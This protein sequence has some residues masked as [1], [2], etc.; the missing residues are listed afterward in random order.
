M[1]RLL[2]FILLI[3]LGCDHPGYGKKPQSVAEV[4]RHD[5][6]SR[7]PAAKSVDTIY[8]LLKPITAQ[9]ISV[10]QYAAY[11]RAA[12]EAHEAGNPDSTLLKDMGNRIFDEGMAIDSTTTLYYKSVNVIIYTNRNGEKCM[13]E[14]W[15]F[16]DKELK[17][18]PE[19]SFVEK[20]SRNDD[21]L[22]RPE[23]YEP[24]TPDDK[25]N[26]LRSGFVEYHW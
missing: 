2:P 12:R 26:L 15:L 16:F 14:D 22:I 18:I 5:F 23:P 20:V 24:I 4:V 6:L 8:I 25:Q 10:M 19:S 9:T 13:A 11:C 21:E 1:K 3:C 17:R 7:L